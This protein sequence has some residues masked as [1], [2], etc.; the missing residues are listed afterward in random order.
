MA[1]PSVMDDGRWMDGH[2]VTTGCTCTKRMEKCI[3]VLVW[4]NGEQFA[5]RCVKYAYTKL[6]ITK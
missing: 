3:L 6:K 1:I 5:F 2:P 4:E